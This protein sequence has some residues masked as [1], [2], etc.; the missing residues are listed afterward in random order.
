MA[1]TVDEQ[2]QWATAL[3]ERIGIYLETA[4]AVKCSLEDIKAGRLHDHEDV[5]RE[6]GDG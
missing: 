5:K 4:N 3:A 1:E 2:I 6:L